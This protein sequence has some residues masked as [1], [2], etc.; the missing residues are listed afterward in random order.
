MLICSDLPESDYRVIPVGAAVKDNALFAPLTYYKLTV[1]VVG[2]PRSLNDEATRIGSQFLH[3][4]VLRRERFLALAFPPSYD[5]VDW[6]EANAEDTHQVRELVIF[7]DIEVVEF[8][9]RTPV[10]VAR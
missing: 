9:P 6:L 10:H 2:L 5:T 4:A 1:P 3:Q 8:T 7:D